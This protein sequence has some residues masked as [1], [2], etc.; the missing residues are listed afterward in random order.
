M[1]VYRWLIVALVALLV[2][3]GVTPAAPVARVG[4]V[5]LTRTDLDA[6][7]KN[8]QDEL[9]KQGTAEDQLPNAQQI[10]EQ[11]VE[12]FVQQNIVLKI[13]RDRNIAITDQEIDKQIAEIDT[14][15][16]S[17]GQGQTLDGAVKANLGL[18]DARDAGFRPFVSSLLAQQKIAETL[19]TTDSVRA[20]IQQQVEAEAATEVTKADVQHILV[21]T[22]EEAN[23][24]LTRLNAGETFEALA[25]ELSTDPGSKDNGGKYEGIEPG[26]FVPEFDKAMFE[27]LEPGQTTATP[28]KTDF[29]YHII[30]LIS[31]TTGPRIAPDEI[32]AI[33]DQQVAQQLP[34][35]QQEALLALV[36]EE[37][38]KAKES[39]DIVEPVYPTAAPFNVDPVPEPTVTP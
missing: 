36:E 18:A 19:V 14:N 24:V 21:A 15:I 37:R 33:V 27:D 8:V 29:G 38:T 4:D 3:C 17:S 31:R 23:Q 25:A 13:A 7:I 26:Q 28:V 6:R 32:P 10:E 34:Y 9:K 16:T 39:G 20:E 2:G 30:R 22:E 11:L 35:K 12:L 5:S 1:K